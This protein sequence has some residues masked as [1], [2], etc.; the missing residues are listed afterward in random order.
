[1]WSGWDPEAPRAN[2]GLGLTAP[3][4]TEDGKPIVATV[5][6]EFCS[7][8]RA[9]A[10]EVFKLSYE[11]ATSQEARLTVRER[12][13]DPPREIAWTQLDPRSIRLAEGKPQPGFLYEFTYRGTRP[14]VLGLGFAATRDVVSFLRYDRRG[15]AATGG[16][17]RHAL[18][19]GFSQ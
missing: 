19:I 12:E 18:A 3:V 10:L 11:M 5:R 7:G 9:G 17:I 4:A 13:A 2:M 14:K 15:L 1:V 16:P 6:D 8:T